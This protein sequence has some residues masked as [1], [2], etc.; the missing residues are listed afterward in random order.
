MAN[1]LGDSQNIKAFLRALG[2]GNSCSQF[3]LS[4]FFPSSNNNTFAIPPHYDEAKTLST[5]HNNP[6][7][8]N[9]VA[10]KNDAGKLVGVIPSATAHIIDEQ[11]HL[12]IVFQEP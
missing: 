3:S 10:L 7:F 12:N 4:S 9:F 6:I 11:I 8:G 2:R 5:T 1:I